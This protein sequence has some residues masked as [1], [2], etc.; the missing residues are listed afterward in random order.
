MRSQDRADR[1]I[2]DAGE[3]LRLLGSVPVGRLVFT[4]GGLPVIRLVNFL[5]DTDTIVF[6]SD[7]PEWLRAAHRGDVVAFEVDDVDSSQHLAWTVTSIGH[8]SVVPAA[9]A[10]DLERTAPSWVRLRG[11]PLIRLGVESLSGRRGP[12]DAQGNG[13]EAFPNRHG[14]RTVAT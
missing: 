4:Q 1:E 9:E 8:L 10:A 12:I 5:V 14:L 2:L 13:Y 11:R 7:D 3:C 6:A